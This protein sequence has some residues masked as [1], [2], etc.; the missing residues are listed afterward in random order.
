MRE[1]LK[2]AFDQVHA[3]EAL[4][5]RTLASLARRARE[6][7]RRRSGAARRWLPATACAALFL[8]VGH[9]LY[10]TPTVT[11]SV[12]VN[13]SVELGV[14]RFDRVVSAEGRNDDGSALLDELSL[15]YLDYDQAVERLLENGTVAQLLA[16][17]A[18]MAITVVGTGDAQSAQ[19]LATLE[20]RTAG[21]ENTYCRDATSE[22][23]AGAHAAGLSYGKYRILLELQA[24]DPTL[25]ADDVRAM[26]MGELRA[27]LAELSGEESA[28]TGGGRG[29]GHGHRYG[30]G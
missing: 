30:A 8:L 27:L 13:P 10:F 28:S 9:W 2:A 1:A 14:N 18:E 19:I 25:S 23:V 12:D 7:A 22:E 4:R 11:I 29:M 17:G 16:D 24:L 3:D 15:R 21:T 20:A 5:E 6:P 26:G